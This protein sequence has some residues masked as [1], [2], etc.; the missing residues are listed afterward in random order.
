[1]RGTDTCPAC[2]QPLANDFIN[3]KGTAHITT[4]SAPPPVDHA[5][6]A[7]H[8]RL[9]MDSTGADGGPPSK[10]SFREH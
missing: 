10:D 5:C 9:S 8:C 4:G 6:L 7:A 1:V 2:A 3:P